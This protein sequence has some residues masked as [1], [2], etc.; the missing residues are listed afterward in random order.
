M[1]LGGSVNRH[2]NAGQTISLACTHS[3][4]PRLA[5]LRFLQKGQEHKTM[6]GVADQ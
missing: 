3:T 4:S 1:L 2:N 5:L 6:N